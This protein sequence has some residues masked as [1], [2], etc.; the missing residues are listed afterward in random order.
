MKIFALASAIAV[1]TSPNVIQSFTDCKLTITP[2]AKFISLFSGATKIVSFAEISDLQDING[3]TYPSAS[4]LAIALAPSLVE[5]IDATDAIWLYRGVNL[6]AD[7]AVN[8]AWYT[9]VTVGGATRTINAFQAPR[10]YAGSTLYRLN[11]A[12][13]VASWS[14]SPATLDTALDYCFHYSAILQRRTSYASSQFFT[15]MGAINQ[16][17]TANLPTR[18]AGFYLDSVNANI[19][20]VA[21]WQTPVYTDTLVPDTLSEFYWYEVD[22]FQNQVRGRI[23]DIDRNLLFDSGLSAWA[24]SENLAPHFR[25]V[26]TG[27][28][29]TVDY[30]GLAS[31]YRLFF[32]V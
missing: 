2:D 20:W 6:N 29:T 32:E 8:V 11:A 27:G 28:A 3:R 15:V 30:S 16:S 22:V 5:L 25:Q 23:Y 9:S 12:G 31:H 10:G 4:V 1:E 24:R 7:E 14:F 19:S 18:G 21:D 13:T 17:G 26:R